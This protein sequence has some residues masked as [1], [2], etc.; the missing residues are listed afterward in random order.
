M[1]LIEE[2][3][4]ILTPAIR[5][6]DILDLNSKIDD[7]TYFLLIFKK[8]RECKV[9]FKLQAIKAINLS[10]EV[11]LKRE[12]R[13]EVKTT[14]EDYLR[15]GLVDILYKSVFEKDCNNFLKKELSSFFKTLRENQWICII[16][17]H[18]INI[19]KI[20]NFG[21]ISLIP[22]IDAANEF[23]RLGISKDKYDF[24]NNKIKLY[25]NRSALML[26]R[27]N[28]VDEEFAKKNAFILCEEFLNIVRGFN[29]VLFTYE[30]PSMKAQSIITFCQK[31]DHFSLNQF[32]LDADLQAK[33]LQFD[34]F[35]EKTALSQ[36]V[37]PDLEKKKFL[38]IKRCLVWLG[39]SNL[40]ADE[41]QILLYYISALE[42]LLLSD[43]ENSGSKH[44]IAERCAFLL[45][46]SPEQRKT[47]NQLIIDSYNIR[48]NIAHG[49]YNEFIEVFLLE[50][51]KDLVFRSAIQLITDDRIMSIKDL[52]R[53]VQDC[54]FS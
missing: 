51:I 18:N 7:S 2:V 5:F 30:E 10:I 22:L 29:N 16:P 4:K 46:R 41:Q 21:I 37:N 45:G 44:I 36:I 35:A 17:I 12:D 28:G 53:Y 34:D 20:H 43:E 48:S 31:T 15:K 50:K 13:K 23:Q 39:K 9:G 24:C 8:E 1:R 47:I 14:S 40:N 49:S 33:S 6:I 27:L 11:I 19:E 26:I 52:I 54:K 3:S 42:S 32:A 38:N 25:Q